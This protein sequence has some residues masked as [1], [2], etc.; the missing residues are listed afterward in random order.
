MQLND[1]AS[2]VLYLSA[3]LAAIVFAYIGQ[4]KNL[5]FMCALAI[6]VPVLLAGFRY[7]AGTDSMTYRTLYEEIGTEKPEITEWRVSS[8]SLEPFVVYASVIGNAL[9]LPPSFLFICFA[10]I[11]TGFFYL[12]TKLFSKKRAWL[13]YGMLILIVFPESLNMMRQLAANS[14]QVFVLAHIFSEHR[15]NKRVR[16]TPIIALLALSVCLHYSSLLLLPV[17][18]LPFIIKH[19]R[20]HTLT[21]LLCI[22]I[23]ACILAFPAL[24]KFVIDLGILSNRHYETFMEMPGSLV[25]VKFFAAAILSGVLIANYCRT[26]KLFYKQY[27]LLM[28]LGTAYAAVGF[29]SGYLG[30]L[31]MFFWIII[32]MFIGKFI[33]QLFEKENHRVAVCSAV[34]IGYF[35]LYFCV[36][37]FNAIMPYDFAL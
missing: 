26:Q 35:V 21:L 9:H 17:F 36:L 33:C 12:T 25:N 27:S 22:F 28:L 14:I 31:A 13:L 34:A 15:K 20:G 4:K 5:K 24:L 23:G 18:A 1:F 2:I 16:I 11:T 7:T 8:G 37:G 19:I 3:F 32:A 30:R 10:T 29:Y 6:I